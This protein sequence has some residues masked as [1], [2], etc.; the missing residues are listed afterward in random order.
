MA[1]LCSRLRR[2][3]SLKAELRAPLERFVFNCK[4][5]LPEETL[6]SVGQHTRK[7]FSR[8][9]PPAQGRRVVLHK[10]SRMVLHKC[11][12]ALGQ[13][14]DHLR[15]ARQILDGGDGVPTGYQLRQGLRSSFPSS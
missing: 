5:V 10:C 6:C 1:L 15:V 9:E 2:S 3:L 11:K 14:N 13:M 12:S 4:A 7:A 8:C